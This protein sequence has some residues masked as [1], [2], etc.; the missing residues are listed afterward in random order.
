MIKKN[1][2]FLLIFY[3]FSINSQT[4]V[5]TM[6]YNLLNYDS[7]F[8]SQN[9]TPYLKTILE[10]I[11][12]DLF[13]VCELKNETASNYLFN[14]AVL[15]YNSKFKKADFNYS[16]S[17]ATGL[18]QMVYFNSDKLTLEKST[19]LP[20]TTRDI[21]HYT[22]KLNTEN[23]ETTPIN[24]EFFVTHLKAS[25][26]YTNRQKRLSSI[27][28]F[29]TYLDQLD[30]NSFVLF[31]GDFNFYTSNEEGFTA[32]IDEY[33]SIQI[34][35]PINR[36]CPEFPNDDKDYFDDDYNSTY[37]WNN[38][39]FADVH[40]QATRNYQLNGDG[41]GGGMDD[42][43]DFIMMSKNLTTS[44]D[45]YY[46]DN[47]YKTIGNNGNC[48]NSYVSNTNCT[49][50]FTQELRNALYNFSDHL[51]IV[52]E[53]ETSENVLL[54]PNILPVSFINT[55]IVKNE[56]TLALK[57][58]VNSIIIY[59]QLGQIMYQTKNINQQ[60]LKIDIRHFSKGIYY[61]KTDA[62]KTLKF[63]KN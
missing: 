34:V 42:R 7:D 63:V 62:Y 51:P 59:N 18:L 30:P 22:F 38:S 50:A 8:N 12:P 13:M 46:V 48:Y 16:N 19:I 54:I 36:L 58:N 17:P 44:S 35:D 3:G 41:A 29:T 53:V 56:I 11:Q 2:L 55:N 52:M 28:E 61:L 33:N 39:S 40:S 45:L 60:E 5:K 21:N 37:F 25:S 10:D 23:S 26:G 15:T 1:I 43:F 57:E 6:F 14:N 24:L 27:R 32:L 20:T 4:T 9:R 47:S 49:G 31:A